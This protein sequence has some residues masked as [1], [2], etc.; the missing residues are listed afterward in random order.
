VIIV[1]AANYQ[2][3]AHKIGILQTLQFARAKLSEIWNF[4]GLKFPFQHSNGVGFNTLPCVPALCQPVTALRGRE[5]TNSYRHPERENTRGR[6]HAAAVPTQA[7]QTETG[8]SQEQEH[9]ASSAAQGSCALFDTW[10]EVRQ[11]PGTTATS[12][13]RVQKRWE[14]RFAAECPLWGGIY[15]IYLSQ[16]LRW[17][18]PYTNKQ[19]AV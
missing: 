15:V 18:L 3:P 12:A 1:L 9:A 17:S 4:R 7:Q 10:F 6:T 13:A 2:L 5:H 19:L 11:L 8:K 14:S 16:L